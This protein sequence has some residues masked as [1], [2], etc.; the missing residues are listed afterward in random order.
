[1]VTIRPC[2]CSCM[3]GSAASASLAGAS[4]MMATASSKSAAV[5][6]STGPTRMTPALLIT[7]S[8]RPYCS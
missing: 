3:T 8:S 5:V 1:M 6:D 4:A 2:P 7:M